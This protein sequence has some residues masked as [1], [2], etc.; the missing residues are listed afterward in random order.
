LLQQTSEQNKGLA[1]RT[2]VLRLASIA[3][4]VLS[5]VAIHA[6]DIGQVG[7]SLEWKDGKARVSAGSNLVILIWDAFALILF[8]GLM[9]R[10]SNTSFSGVPS[11]GRR[12]LAFLID[13][14]FSLLTISGVGAI[15]PL[16][17]EAGR[18]GHFAW[19]FQRDYAVSSDAWIALPTSLSF[20]ALMVLYFVLPLTRGKQTVGGFIMR[21]K[22][23][24]P[25]GGGGRFTFWQ[26]LR[27]TYYEFNG[28]SPF[29][30]LS[31]DWDN[32]GQGRTWYDVKSN[33]TVVLVDENSEQTSVE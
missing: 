29:L 22:V 13:F 12:I 32:D 33:C 9:L 31:K 7:D 18:T 2:N 28:L 30:W 3:L 15:I 25:F 23:T 14:W 6:F 10:K 16:L 19:H 27:R 11:R 20:M 5:F 24:P 1:Y 21:L 17:L 4:V 8:V 26:A